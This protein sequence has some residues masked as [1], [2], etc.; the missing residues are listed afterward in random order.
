MRAA[1]SSPTISSVSGFHLI[2]R[3]SLYAISPSRQPVFVR[4]AMLMSVAAL[5]LSRMLSTNAVKWLPARTGK[6]LSSVGRMR[7]S[8][9][10]SGFETIVARETKS[11][12]FSP[13]NS[14]PLRFMSDISTSTP[15]L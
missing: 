8:A 14:T 12:P 9:I 3:L 6:S 7:V 11:V 1:S 5:R 15:F 10:E 13:K 4:C 2:V